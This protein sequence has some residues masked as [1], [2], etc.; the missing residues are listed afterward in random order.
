MYL[1][2]VVVVLIMLLIWVSW[3]ASTV[4]EDYMYGFWVAEGDDFCESSDIKSMMMFI[5]APCVQYCPPCVTR[6]CYIVIMDNLSSQG[7]TMSYYPGW[8][9]LGNDVYTVRASVDFDEEAIWPERVMMSVDMSD[10][11]LTVRSGDTL[12]ARLNKQH[13]I[14]NMAKFLPANDK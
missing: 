2:A 5:G 8:S 13:Y 10:G 6:A 7:F 9:G 12:Y 11:V 3:C 4:N 14:T 1:V